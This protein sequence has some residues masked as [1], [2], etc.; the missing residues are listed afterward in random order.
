LP[1]E[2]TTLSV[3]FEIIIAVVTK[4]AIFGDIA[5][6]SPYENRHFGGTYHLHLQCRKSAE[7][8]TSVQQMARQNK[9]SAGISVIWGLAG[10]RKGITPAHIGSLLCIAW[11]TGEPMGSKRWVGVFKGQF[12]KICVFGRTGNV[13]WPIS[14]D[15]V[16]RIQLAGKWGS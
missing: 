9:Q 1:F 16:S 5:P 2:I 15:S 7:Q 13:K 14:E 4:V 3:G 10:K 12:E 8:E 11:L 6:C